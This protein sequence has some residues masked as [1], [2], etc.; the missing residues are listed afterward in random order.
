MTRLVLG[1]GF[2]YRHER[3]L[4]QLRNREQARTQVLARCAS[5]L[6]LACPK[7]GAAYDPG[8]LFCGECASPLTAGATATPDPATTPQA[9][10]TDSPVAE[11]RLASV[12]FADL[13]GFTTIVEG[14]DAEDIRELLHHYF[15]LAREVIGR[16]GGTVEKFIGDAVMAVWGAPVARE[17]DAATLPLEAGGGPLL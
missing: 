8:D 9:P 17:A 13:V 11:R 4:P 15:E 5:P 7:C 12:L 2:G 6:G 10:T 1:S 14:H 16:Y 3:D